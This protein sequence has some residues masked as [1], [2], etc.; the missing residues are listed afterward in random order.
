VLVREV[1]CL[2]VA[3]GEMEQQA[4]LRLVHEKLCK[5]AA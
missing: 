5:A 2:V 1:G 3:N 4:A